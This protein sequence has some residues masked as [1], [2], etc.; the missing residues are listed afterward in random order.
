MKLSTYTLKKSDKELIGLLNKDSL[1]NSN[2]SSDDIRKINAKLIDEFEIWLY[3]KFTL[4]GNENKA[5]IK[6]QLAEANLIQT[7]NKTLFNY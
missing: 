1:I 3:K 5:S 6:V 4:Y 2:N 7:K